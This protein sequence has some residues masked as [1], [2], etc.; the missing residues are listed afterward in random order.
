MKYGIWRHDDALGNSAEHVYGLAQY[1]DVNP[2]ENP[3]I[4][5]EHDFQKYFALCIPNI[6]ENNIKYFPKVFDNMDITSVVGRLQ[7]KLYSTDEFKD[8]LEK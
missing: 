3:I 6:T 7:E 8:I 2:D 4:Y 5:V 1:L